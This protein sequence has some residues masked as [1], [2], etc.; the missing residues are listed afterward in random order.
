MA[1]TQIDHRLAAVAR[2]A[3]VH[4][5]KQIYAHV[6]AKKGQHWQR[7]QWPFEL[8]KNTIHAALVGH[9]MLR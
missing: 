4:V 9:L 3:V 5:L 6:P 1:C 2:V 8:T 7:T